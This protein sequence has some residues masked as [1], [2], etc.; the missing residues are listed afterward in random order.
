[1]TPT[2][3]LE[4]RAEQTNAAREYLVRSQPWQITP[5]DD[6]RAALT[7]FGNNITDT[8][9]AAWWDIHGFLWSVGV[10]RSH[11]GPLRKE[12]IVN[13]NRTAEAVKS[14]AE[15]ALK[16]AERYLELFARIEKAVPSVPQSDLTP[17]FAPVREWFE[18]CEAAY[19]GAFEHW[20]PLRL[21]TK[22]GI[23]AWDAAG[24]LIPLEECLREAEA[25][26]SPEERD[27]LRR[28]VAAGG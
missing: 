21:P 24:D 27:E 3:L 20:E 10:L 14:A 23:D 17:V 12:A 6:R 1:M 16:Y 22:E 7:W 2:F 5:E 13:L 9:T 8:L 15:A 4:L 28:R 19:A 18:K 11:S 26:I 25:R